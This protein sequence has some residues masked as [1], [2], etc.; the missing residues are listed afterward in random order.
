M[1]GVPCPN[2]AGRVPAL[3]R[4]HAR[5]RGYVS[6]EPRQHCYT[7]NHPH[8]RVAVTTAPPALKA[9]AFDMPPNFLA[10]VDTHV[11]MQL[12]GPTDAGGWPG[13]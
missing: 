10:V 6:R 4:E 2:N 11:V 12:I 3:P 7:V 1:S 8:A 13:T 9:A 5:A